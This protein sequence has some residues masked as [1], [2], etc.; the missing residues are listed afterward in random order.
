MWIAVL[1]IGA[2]VVLF[3]VLK[4]NSSASDQ[5]SN[6]TRGQRA[7]SSGSNYFKFDM[8]L[9]ER[10]SQYSVASY[11]EENI[12]FDFG[13]IGRQKIGSYRR[14]ENCQPGDK[15]LDSGKP[16]YVFFDN[17]GI[18]IG[19]VDDD[20]P[21]FIDVSRYGLYKHFK[22]MYG[23]GK[24]EGEY[25]VTVKF[26]NPATDLA[27]KMYDSGGN[28]FIYDAKTDEMI[29]HYV[30]SKIGAACAFC[31]LTAEFH[32]DTEYAKFRVSWDK[33]EYKR[34]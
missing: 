1:M 8:P 13:T 31:A 28:G 29:G 22:E 4:R 34:A 2:V 26:P 19:F 16:G 25:F 23:E 10:D 17:D 24:Q 30:G 18:E 12:Y 11:D 32:M 15:F 3:F 9:S 27:G 21:D 5:R 33:T 14:R 6:T 20:Y 7:S